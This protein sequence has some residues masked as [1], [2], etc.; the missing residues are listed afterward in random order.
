MKTRHFFLLF[1]L[2]SLLT[3]V[4]ACTQVHAE[5]PAAATSTNVTCTFD[6]PA[7]EKLELSTSG[8]ILFT[9]TDGEVSIELTVPNT[10]VDDVEVYVKDNKLVF[11]NKVGRNLVL[12]RDARLTLTVKAPMVRQITL[13]G[14]GD[15]QILS[16]FTLDSDLKVLINGSGDLKFAQGVCQDFSILT[17][18]SGDVVGK[19]LQAASLSASVNGSGDL[20]L[21]HVQA[22]NISTAVKGSGDVDLAGKCD[23]ASFTIVGSGDVEA[24]KLEATKVAVKIVGSGDVTCYPLE[25]LSVNRIGSGTI[26]YKGNPAITGLAKKGVYPLK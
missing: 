16:A 7:F 25:S 8:D 11:R 15:I 20:K 12:P 1:L 21:D 9:P 13:N 6:L 19:S 3:T 22:T 4:T 23:E 10:V 24:K 18:G 17:N 5:H 14:S 26:G 2:G